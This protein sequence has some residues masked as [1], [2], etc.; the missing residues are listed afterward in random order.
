M[1]IL[2]APLLVCLLLA[3]EDKPTPKIPLGKE[4][5][6]VTGPLD[7]EGYV[8]YEAALNERL[9]KGIIPE[10][11][12]NVLLWKALGPTPEGGKGMPAEYFRL[13]GIEEPPERG[14]Y[15][16]SMSQYAKDRL[17][18]ES[19]EQIIAIEDKQTRASKR[20]WT[21]KDLPEIAGWLKANE[22]PLALVVEATKRPDYFNPLVTRKTEKGSTGLIGAMLPSVHKC[23]ELT[24]A[25]AARAMLH[26]GEGRFNEA[27]QDLLAC[28]RLGRLVARGA[29]LIELL[30]G[31]AIDWYVSTAELAFL[32]RAELTTK[33]VQ[34]CLRDLQELPPMPSPA[35]KIDLGERFVLL[36]IVMMF[37]RHGFQ[38]IE[39]LAG[40]PG[41]VPVDRF[42]KPDPQ[43]RKALDAF[44]WEAMLRNANRTYSRIAAAQRIKDHAAREKELD[45]L[46]QELKALQKDATDSMKLFKAFLEGKD[47]GKTVFKKI[48][49]VLVRLMLP[50]FR[51]MQGAGDRAE[52]TQRNQYLAF[53][54]A[55]YRLDQGRYP[56]KLE[57]LAPK[58]LAA[59]PNDLFSGKALIYRP[60]E[61]SYLLYSVGVN[62]IDEGG[63]W[64]DDDPPGDDP[65]VR[66]PLPE[67]KPKK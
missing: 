29:R 53:A 66:M 48:G 62:G 3:G 38:L 50:A 36:D 25:L 8:D 16:V 35:D 18:L 39:G 1:I 28:H 60:T 4:T 47:P 32:D 51:K 40:G 46:E 11:N 13:L 33:Q 7:K 54:L 67:L 43:T 57:D 20:P 14:E 61:N 64:Y 6:H 37:H 21:A 42:K 41:E 63:R 22:K 30:C 49:D 10:K 23:R 59:V 9:G 24:T 19:G 56:A 45:R 15:F 27:W 31:V 5:T 12:A 52:Q 34:N 26:T 17:K 65:R 55:A 44:D 58:Y 2:A